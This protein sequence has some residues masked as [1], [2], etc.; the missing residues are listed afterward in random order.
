[1]RYRERGYSCSGRPLK[2]LGV[3]SF[4]TMAG[5]RSWRSI[6]SKHKAGCKQQ[7]TSSV[8]SLD[9]RVV[10]LLHSNCS[11]VETTIL[12]TSGKNS[13]PGHM[14]RISPYV[15]GHGNKDDNV[16][17]HL[18][19]IRLCPS[20]PDK[21]YDELPA[22]QFLLNADRTYLWALMGAHGRSQRYLDGHQPHH[23]W[24]GT[25]SSRYCCQ[26]GIL[27]ACIYQMA[28]GG[29][30]HRLLN[31]NRRPISQRRLAWIGTEEGVFDK[32]HFASLLDRKNPC[33]LNFC[34]SLSTMMRLCIRVLVGQLNLS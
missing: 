7:S 27:K 32:G 14:A 8:P 30:C 15:S 26:G 31:G 10:H 12:P 9:G 29:H 28:Q 4:S 6:T 11:K 23:A 18:N 2:E 33:L 21:Q 19:I 34:V 22:E 3:Y 17:Y 16:R 1:M 13:Y 5:I 24:Q 25:E 20:L